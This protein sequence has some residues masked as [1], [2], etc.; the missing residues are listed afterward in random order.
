MKFSKGLPF[1]CFHSIESIS[2]DGSS[3]VMV[4]DPTSI[5]T[6]EERTFSTFTRTIFTQV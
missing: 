6:T 3:E 1:A 2:C 5:Q 4:P